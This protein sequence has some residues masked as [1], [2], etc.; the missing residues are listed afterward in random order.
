[1]D[2]ATAFAAA[3][4]KDAS[5]NSGVLDSWVLSSHTEKE[6]TINLGDGLGELVISFDEDGAVL[7]D[8]NNEDFDLGD[9]PG[10]F[11]AD[12]IGKCAEDL[13]NSPAESIAAA[14][15]RVF[16]ISGTTIDKLVFI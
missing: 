5:E 6:A 2:I 14:I 16:E 4:S 1:M 8:F 9:G 11:L 10:M 3:K 13:E 7:L 15:L 12:V